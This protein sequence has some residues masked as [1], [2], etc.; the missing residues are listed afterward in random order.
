MCTVSEVLELVLWNGLQS[1]H[2]ITPDVINVI[3]MPYFNISLSSGTEKSQWGLDPVNREGVPAQFT[4]LE[5]SHRQCYSVSSFGTIFAHTFLMSRSSV[6]IFPTVSLLMFACCAMST[7]FKHN[8]TY[9]R[10]VF[11]GSAHCWPS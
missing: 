10:D 4:S 2:R 3:K 6:K 9:F 11:F 7:I 1:C 8:L 5:I